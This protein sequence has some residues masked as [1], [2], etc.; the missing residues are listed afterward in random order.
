M[1][2][3]QVHGVFRRPCCCFFLF[4]FDDCFFDCVFFFSFVVSYTFHCDFLTERRNFLCCDLANNDNNQ[5]SKPSVL[6]LLLLL[7]SF[8]S[9]TQSP[10]RSVC[11]SLKTPS[12]STLIIIVIIIINSNNNNNNKFNCGI[13]AFE[14]TSSP[15][16]EESHQLRIPVSK[17]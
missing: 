2:R 16:S 14:S 13:R 5:K 4:S 1:Y 17:Q 12:N 6:L 10:A 8:F 11:L 15:L 7:G 9:K 3:I